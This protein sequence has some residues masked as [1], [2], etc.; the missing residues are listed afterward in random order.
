MDFLFFHKRKPDN[1]NVK[2]LMKFCK[3][4]FLLQVSET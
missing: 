2:K 3:E 4:T 1:V